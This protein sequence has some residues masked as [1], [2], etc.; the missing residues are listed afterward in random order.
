MTSHIFFLK[1]RVPN[2]LSELS[3][4]GITK[5]PVTLCFVIDNSSPSINSISKSSKRKYLYH[6][7]DHYSNV[8]TTN[9]QFNLWLVEPWSLMVITNLPVGGIRLNVINSSSTFGV[10]PILK[11]TTRG[12]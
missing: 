9:D 12:L 3:C 11:S 10:I 1:G 4:S 6:V 8:N 7:T 2:L 5:H